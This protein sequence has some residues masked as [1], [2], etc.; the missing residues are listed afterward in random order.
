MPQARQPRHSS[1]SPLQII[2]LA[3]GKNC[4][5]HANRLRTGAG[6]TGTSGLKQT[7]HYLMAAGPDRVAGSGEL[8]VECNWFQACCTVLHSL[9]VQP[10]PVLCIYSCRCWE[11]CGLSLQPSDGWPAVQWWP[12]LPRSGQHWPAV[13]CPVLHNPQLLSSRQLGCVTSAVRAG[14][15]GP[16]HRRPAGPASASD[17]VAA[18]PAAPASMTQCSDSSPD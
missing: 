7:A 13:S 16:P 15:A 14:R 18:E 2:T 17:V 11:R 12:H 10:A 1:R 5:R 3:P 8:C 4:I 6:L 9:S